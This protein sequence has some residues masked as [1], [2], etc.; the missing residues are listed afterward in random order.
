MHIH[1][2]YSKTY[3]NAPLYGR[4]DED[5]MFNVNDTVNWY[6]DEGGIG[7]ITSMNKLCSYTR[8][9]KYEATSWSWSLW[10]RMGNATKWR[11]G[12]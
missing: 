8:S 11:R 9:T 3:V 10:Q 5:P 6:I 2:Y 4:A 12:N 1:A 7:K